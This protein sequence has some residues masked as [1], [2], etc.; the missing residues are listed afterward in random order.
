M[1]NGALPAWIAAVVASVVLVVT[2][3]ASG[4]SKLAARVG[5]VEDHVQVLQVEIADRLARI[6]EQ[7]L[8]HLKTHRKR[9]G[10]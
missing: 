2:L 1:K 9:K 5:Q 3:V 10:N 7:Q 4:D 6:E 8:A